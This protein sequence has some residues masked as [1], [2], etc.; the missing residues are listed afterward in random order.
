MEVEDLTTQLLMKT[1]GKIFPVMIIILM[2]TCFQM[3][4]QGAR[5][6]EK[7]FLS[8]KEFKR[9]YSNHFRNVAEALRFS[10]V[11]VE[12]RFTRDIR[13]GD[14]NIRTIYEE[15]N[16]GSGFIFDREGHVITDLRNVLQF[17][18]GFI[19]P[20]SPRQKGAQVGNYIKVTLYNGDSFEAD[21]VG[22]DG[23]TGL[24]VLKL[25]RA[26]PDDLQPVVF[27]PVDDIEV[28][29]PVMILNYNYI[30]KNLLG[31]AFGV[32]AALRGQY[33]SL[34]QSES[35]FMMIN[36]PKIGGNDGGII[37]DVYGRVL[38]M[39]SSYTPYRETSELH[40]GIPVDIISKVCNSLIDKGVYHRPY[41]GFTLLE[42]NE[43][44]K[45]QEDIDFDEGMYVAYVE[46]DS[47]AEDAGL[48][49]GD[50]IYMWDGDILEDV[51][52]IMNTFEKKKIGAVIEIEFFHRDFNVWDSVAS[53]YTLEIQ[54][55]DE[56][57][58]LE[59]ARE[60]ARKYL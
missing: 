26:N 2:V 40:Y 48:M 30:A 10:V 11:S 42:L 54:E 28:G 32:V 38:A 34:N 8:T 17:P 52:A 21:F 22:I 53:E 37:I 4:A 27:G 1:A 3:P 41:Y 31:G 56:E 51:S 46:P 55:T 57:D 20:L 19:S 59:R 44:L 12:A 24:A 18:S 9:V 49:K 36:F 13:D 50:V 60:R 6:G 16:Y 35:E 47:P 25:K 58:E 23:S 43:S 7:E 5:E 15:G 39:V 29:E 33:A 45:L 14:G